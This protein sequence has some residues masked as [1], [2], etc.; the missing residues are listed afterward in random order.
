MNKMKYIY[1]V[2]LLFIIIPKYSKEINVENQLQI[3]EEITSKKLERER[4]RELNKDIDSLQLNE[5]LERMNL[6]KIKDSNLIIS[7]L[8]T[9]KNEFLYFKNYFTDSEILTFKEEHTIF[10][11]SDGVYRLGFIFKRDNNKISNNEDYQLNF[12]LYAR[13]R[14]SPYYNFDHKIIMFIHGKENNRILTNLFQYNYREAIQK[15]Y[16]N[17]IIKIRLLKT[18]TQEDMNILYSFIQMNNQLNFR[19][20]G[21]DGYFDFELKEEKIYFYKEFL[22]YAKELNLY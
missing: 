9:P 12:T 5:A 14:L 3:I 10:H 18:L 6:G 15:V 22:K 11:N 7:P 16:K 17:G 20:E 8:Y 2:I 19:L 4:E 1:L 21:S 13:K